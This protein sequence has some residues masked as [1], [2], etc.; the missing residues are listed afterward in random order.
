MRGDQ[1]GAEVVPVC[2]AFDRSARSK[3][4]LLLWGADGNHASQQGSY[5]GALT[6]YYWISGTESKA[7]LHLTKG[8]QKDAALAMSAIAEEVVSV[9]RKNPKKIPTALQWRTSSDLSQGRR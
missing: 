6:I 3:T 8:L 1:S 5:L 4:L 2:Y 9:F 7:T